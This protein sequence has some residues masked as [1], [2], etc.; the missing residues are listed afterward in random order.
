MRCEVAELERALREKEGE[1][2]EE[3][4]LN[5]TCSSNQDD[6]RYHSQNNYQTCDV[7]AFLNQKLELADRSNMVLEERLKEYISREEQLQQTIEEY[8]K[9]ESVWQQKVICL[10][11]EKKILTQKIDELQAQLTDTKV[12]KHTY[13]N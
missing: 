8:E 7:I 12:Y 3:R 2:F 10:E 6:L 11:S 5:E 13:I 4:L 1:V 9:S